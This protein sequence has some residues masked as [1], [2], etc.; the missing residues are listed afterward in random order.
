[1]LNLHECRTASEVRALARAVHQHR[2][3]PTVR[4]C[5]IAINDLSPGSF[6]VTVTIIETPRIQVPDVPLSKIV[7]EVCRFYS[8]TKLDM[9]SDRRGRDIM[10]P[11]HIAYY[12][13]RYLST[14][15]LPAIGRAFA[16]RDHTTILNG[17]RNIEVRRKVE[18]DLD[19][20]L[21]QL[22]SKLVVGS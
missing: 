18:A 12:L 6:P 2:T 8:V 14:Q 5:R 1:M 21:I 3:R 9:M 20:D 11:R 17:V 4:R 15:S 22:Q 19:A 7:D 13:C 10:R 16:G